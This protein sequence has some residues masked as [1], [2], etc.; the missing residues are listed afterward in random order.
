VAALSVGH[1]S[2][3]FVLYNSGDYIWN[4]VHPTLDELLRSSSSSSSS[5][6]ATSGGSTGA[7]EWVELGPDGT[8]VALFEYY[9][10]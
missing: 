2:E 9:T 7:V 8:Y 3:W 4:G 6:G 5:F 10:A 1:N